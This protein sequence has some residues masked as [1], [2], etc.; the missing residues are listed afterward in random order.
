M[1]SIIVHAYERNA[2]TLSAIQAIEVAVDPAE[3]M[4]KSIDM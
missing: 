1:F 2:V 4:A 3:P